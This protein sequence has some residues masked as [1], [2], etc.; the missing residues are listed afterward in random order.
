MNFQE[1]SRKTHIN[2]NFDYLPLFKKVLEV[3]NLLLMNLI[4]IDTLIEVYRFNVINLRNFRIYYFFFSQNCCSF[5]F[6][7]HKNFF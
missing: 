2:F 3:Y 1:N 7:K 6:Y 5:Y 4:I